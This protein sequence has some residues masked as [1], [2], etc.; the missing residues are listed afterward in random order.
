[1]QNERAP[2]GAHGPRVQSFSAGGMQIPFEP[3]ITT[4]CPGSP[5]SL[6]MQGASLPGVQITEQ[7]WNL[8]V[9]KLKQLFDMQSCS[10]EQAS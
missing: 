9:M 7:T 1:M 3:E 4:Q 5:R 6:V 8:A 2:I 10:V